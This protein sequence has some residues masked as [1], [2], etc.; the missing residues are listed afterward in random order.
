MMQ[1]QSLRK[2]ETLVV[3]G[4]APEVRQ[5]L[6]AIS[7]AIPMERIE[8][9]NEFYPSHLPVALINAVYRTR[10][11]S[12]APTASS[13]ERYCHHFGIASMR[14]RSWKPI[15]ADEQ[16]T[17]GDLIR[18]FDELGVDR[19]AKVVFQT[20]HGSTEATIRKAKNLLRAAKVLRQI[21]IDFLQDIQDRRPDEID[22]A[23][24]CLP[25]VSAGTIRTLLMYT[26]DDDFVRGDVHVRNFVSSALLQRTISGNR[27][28][29]LVRQCAYELILA[30]R[31][32]DFEIWKLRRA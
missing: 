14:A 24:Q 32:L 18:R 1:K 7:H 5:V 30:P 12:G 27:A 16:E 26:G 25:G 13:A 3:S 6:V 8:L 10:R 17:L 28:I 9:P 15:S 31:F 20:S 2:Q 23:L 11:G 4:I 19:M 21:G 22:D 29:G